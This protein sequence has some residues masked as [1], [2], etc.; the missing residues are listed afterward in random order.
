M[1]DP[2]PPVG[3]KPPAVPPRRR[4]GRDECANCGA[5][6]HGPYCARCGQPD[7]PLR[8]P[9]HHFVGRSLVEF[10]GLDGRVWVTLGALLF[11]PGKLTREYL[12]GRRQRHLRPLRVYLSS[13]LL[14]FVLLSLIDPVGRA[15]ETF[16]RSSDG[17]PDSV[18]VAVRLARADSVVA[19]GLAPDP[20][21]VAQLDSLRA[22]F[23]SLAAPPGRAADSAA[24]SDVRDGFADALDEV[25]DDSSD[26]AG[27]LRRARLEAAILRTMPPDSV[28][29]VEDIRSATYVVYPEEAFMIDEDSEIEGYLRGDAIRQIK[30]GR[31]ESEKMAGVTAFA[32]TAIGFVPTVMFLILPVFALLLKAL[33]VRRGWFYSEHFVFGLHT[34]AFAFVVFSALAVWMWVGWGAAQVTSVGAWLLVASI[35]VYFLVAQKRV[36]GQGWGRTVLKAGLLGVVYN[37]ILFWALVGTVLLAAFLG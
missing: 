29:A 30:E 19:L 15:P 23:D 31:T 17:E 7:H 8:E 24:L 36:Y 28:V 26:A 21:A 11:K 16:F 25:R 20:D 1:N 4:S 18:S 6:L 27:R 9:V 10:F 34:H 33:Y 2:A 3:E 12:D 32:R 5:A 35:P 22:A 13:T 37:V 14:F